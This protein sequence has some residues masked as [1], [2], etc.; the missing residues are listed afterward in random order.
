MG[1]LASATTPFLPQDFAT[2]VNPLWAREL[3]ARVVSV[4]PEA[5][6][7][8]TLVLKPARWSG[9]LAG[10]YVGVGV[11]IGGV[12]H[13][14]TYSLTDPDRVSITVKSLGLVSSQLVALR[15]GAVVRM[16]PAA[17]DFTWADRGPALF[18]TAGSGITPAMGMLRAFRGQLPDITHV[19]VAPSREDVIFGPELRALGHRLLEWH[20]DTAGLL[21]L[22]RLEELVPDW[23]GREVWACGPAALLAAIENHWATAGLG[24]KLHIERFSP[25][26][27]GGGSEGTVTFTRGGASRRTGNTLLE[28]GEEAGVLMPSGCRMGICY[29]CVV[30][31]LSGQVRDV[32][33]GDV[34]GEPGDLVQ[35]CISTPA[36]DCSLDV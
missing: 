31:L 8:A 26:A 28:A 17:G 16:R 6:G 29:G 34:H 7:A 9:H 2:L 19:H 1:L 35:T 18:L 13:W 24:H 23:R 10:Q 4:T 22:D 15:P 3:R 32:R 30:P 36:G 5:A 11:E 12:L 27:L 14:R 25:P 21:T 33:T 20:D